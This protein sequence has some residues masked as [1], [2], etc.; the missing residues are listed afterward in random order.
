MKTTKTMFPLSAFRFP[1]LAFSLPLL[2]FSLPLL[3]AGCAVTTFDATKADGTKV[4]VTNT[5]LLWTTDSYAASIA[6][7]KASLT[8]NK[9]SVD[10][11]AL[12]A[13]VQ[14][15]V[16]GAAAAAKP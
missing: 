8:A 3:F 10:K 13:V 1:L 16:Q 6:N 2:A 12:A 15:A 9:S 4:H 11:E 5:R 14:G 7:D